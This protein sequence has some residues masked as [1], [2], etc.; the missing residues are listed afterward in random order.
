MIHLYPSAVPP[1]E[2]QRRRSE[3][4]GRVVHGEHAHGG[5]SERYRAAVPPLARHVLPGPRH[6]GGVVAPPGSAGQRQNRTLTEYVPEL[7]SSDACNGTGFGA[8]AKVQ[9]IRVLALKMD[10]AVWKRV[11]VHTCWSHKLNSCVIM[12]HELF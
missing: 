6:Y 8:V 2:V 12:I 3:R 5:R 1:H 4:S 10:P 11:R 7:V 9:T